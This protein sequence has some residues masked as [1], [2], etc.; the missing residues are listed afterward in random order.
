VGTLSTGF[1]ENDFEIEIVWHDRFPPIKL[2]VTEFKPKGSGD[3]LSTTIKSPVSET[4]LQVLTEYPLPV[5]LHSTHL[6]EFVK[7]CRRY[8]RSLAATE[9]VVLRSMPPE[10]LILSRVLQAIGRYHDSATDTEQVS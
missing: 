7:K 3:L 2:L 10:N 5:A 1:K 6:R 9:K 8:I 4:H